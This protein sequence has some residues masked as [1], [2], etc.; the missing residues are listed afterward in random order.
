ME[1]FFW[2]SI[3]CITANLSTLRKTG[4]KIATSGVEVF[5]TQTGTTKRIS[6]YR[7]KSYICIQ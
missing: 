3:Q 1:A 7:L 2:L 4:M 6:E 5:N